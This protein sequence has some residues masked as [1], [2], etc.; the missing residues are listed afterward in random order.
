MHGVPAPSRG[1]AVL[2][3]AT[4]VAADHA[5]RIDPHA[6]RALPVAACGRRR[7]LYVIR[8]SRRPPRFRGR[9]EEHRRRAPQRL[10]RGPPP[11]SPAPICQRQEDRPPRSEDAER[12]GARQVRGVAVDLSQAC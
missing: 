6:R 7:E 10:G 12:T 9:R 1:G 11:A 4:L 3:E 2:R 5:R 8:D